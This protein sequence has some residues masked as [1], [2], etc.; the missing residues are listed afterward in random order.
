MREIVSRKVLVQKTL[1][2]PVGYRPYVFIDHPY[3]Q[4]PM[5]PGMVNDIDELVKSHQMMVDTLGPLI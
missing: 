1:I 3:N 2:E 5:V 4:I